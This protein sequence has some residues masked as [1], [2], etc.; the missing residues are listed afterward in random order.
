VALVVVTGASGFLGGAIARALIDRGDRVRCVQRSDVP[1]LRKLG[2]EFVACDLCG[3]GVEVERALA[4]AAAVVH[5]AAKAGVWG[6]MQ[7]FM[8]ANATTTDHVLQAC[9]VNGIRK[10]VYTSTPSVVH[11]GGDVE[12]ADESAPLRPDP[13]SPY[14]V[15]KAH[16]ESLVRAANSPKM[17]TVALRPHLIWGPGD[18]QLTARIVA[19]A[20]AGRLRLV[21]GGYK[22]IDGTYIDNAVEAHLLAL[23]RVEPGA[24]CA[25][26]VYFVANGEPMPQRELVNGILAAA[27]LPACDATIPAWL[28][29]AVG[30]VLEGAWRLL[31]REDEPLMTR[32]VAR[33][34]ATAHWYRLDAVRSD[35]GYQ[36]KVKTAEGLR[37]LAQALRHQG[38]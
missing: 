11:H 31:G 36:G 25:G 34:L 19:R 5:V 37:R 29:Y 21:G 27:G 17:A 6:S 38:R 23:D 9:K 32:F 14:A 10:F 16:A 3:P 22:V 26:K 20:K 12:G 1:E 2:A 28:A 18:T 7:A 15:S 24:A 4:G 35:L 13:R 33:Q 30:A 8:A